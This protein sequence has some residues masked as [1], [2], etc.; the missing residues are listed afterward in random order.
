MS[1]RHLSRWWGLLVVV[2]AAAL[3]GCAT[4]GYVSGAVSTASYRPVPAGSAFVLGDVERLTLTDQRVRQ[5][6]AAEL[7]TRG[8]RQEETPEKAAVI[9]RYSYSLGAGEPL[10]SSVP[11]FGRHRM[12]IE[13]V[14]NYPTYFELRIEGLPPPEKGRAPRILWQGEI[15]SEA[16]SSNLGL[17]APLFVK[18]I[19]QYFDRSVNNQ[20]FGHALK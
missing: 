15:Y 7:V 19:L 6:I 10:V 4:S 1:E 18:D 8:L 12:R 2:L 20:S 11:D 17:M 5:T 3:A 16:S 13:S 14:P 9:V